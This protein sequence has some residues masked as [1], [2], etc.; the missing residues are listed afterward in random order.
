MAD[1]SSDVNVCLNQVWHLT[2]SYG[3]VW[4]H[5]LHVL[6]IQLCY[7]QMNGSAAV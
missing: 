2:T 5:I 7:Q 4:P 6:R 3:C 1:D